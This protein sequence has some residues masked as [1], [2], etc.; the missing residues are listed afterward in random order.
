MKSI[1]YEPM[2]LFGE[3]MDRSW[4]ISVHCTGVRLNGVRK[5]AIYLGKDGLLAKII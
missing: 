2:K 1:I 5:T 3:V 4:P